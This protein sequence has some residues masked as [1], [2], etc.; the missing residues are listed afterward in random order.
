LI[1]DLDYVLFIRPVFY[2]LQHINDV[3]SRKKER[4]KKEKKRKKIGG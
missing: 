1:I 2:D 4:K 3:V